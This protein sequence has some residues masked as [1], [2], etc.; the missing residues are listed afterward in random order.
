MVE[1]LPSVLSL[2]YSDTKKYLDLIKETCK[3][4]HFDVMDGHFVNN[5]SFGP[6]IMKAF[7][8]YTNLVMDVHIMVTNPKKVSDIFINAG[9]DIITFHYEALESETEIIDLAHKIKNN[10]IK[11][12]IS[13]K[14]NTPV[15]KITNLLKYFDLVLVM[16]VE[17]GLG[18]QGFIESS[19]EKIIE[20]KELKNKYNYNYIIEIDGGI[21]DTTVKRVKEAGCE[22]LVSGSYLF[23]GDF[24]EKVKKLLEL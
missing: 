21:N 4:I 2:D 5:L 12:G 22:W 1:I 14:P 8:N 24:K 9:A 7:K 13:I 20:L 11:A 18:G 16:S 3:V 19:L 10:N 6:D 15:S 17:P 23:K